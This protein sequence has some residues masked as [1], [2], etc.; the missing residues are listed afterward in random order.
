MRFATSTSIAALAGA[1]LASASAALAQTAVVTPSNANILNLLSPFLALNASDIGNQTLQGSLNGTVAINNGA[2]ATQQALAISDKNLFG[3]ASNIIG[4][5][6]MGSVQSFGVAANIAGGLPNQAPP[7]GSSVTPSQPVGGY[8]S[9]LG[10]LYVQGVQNGTTGP[11]S[12]VVQLLTGAYNNLTSR[13]LGVAKQYFANGAATNP[14]T[15]TPGYVPVPAA[16]PAGG[17]ATTGALVNAAFLNTQTSATLGRA[18][19][20]SLSGEGLTGVENAAFAASRAFTSSI[21]DE[22]NAWRSPTA[23]APNGVTL[24]APQPVGPL[25]MPKPRPCGF[26]CSR[27][28]SHWHPRPSACGAPGAAVLAAAAPST[29]WPTSARPGRTATSSAASPASTTRC[30]RTS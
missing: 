18:T 1:S 7:A 13:D 28:R 10:S 15:P 17:N 22:M 29:A 20:D 19:L 16:A 26:R 27:V 2:S 12:N 8:G 25:A 9:V 4:T 3:N 14:S 23:A 21:E 30:S 11:L 5:T 6:A 24:A